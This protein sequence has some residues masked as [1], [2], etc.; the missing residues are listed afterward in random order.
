[1]GKKEKLVPVKKEKGGDQ[2]VLEKGTDMTLQRF[3]EWLN[4]NFTKESGKRFSSQDVYGYID[5]G[6]LPYHLGMYKVKI[7]ED[8]EIGVKVV[9]VRNLNKED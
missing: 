3:V 9:R 5:R 4:E 2:L 7:I 8:A 6:N 1:M